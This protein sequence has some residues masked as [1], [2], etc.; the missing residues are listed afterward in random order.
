MATP[1]REKPKEEE[2]EEEEAVL[3]I[4]IA[5]SALFPTI[6][7]TV[8]LLCSGWSWGTLSLATNVSTLVSHLRL[9][10]QPILESS[11]LSSA[12]T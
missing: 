9:S 8:D 11:L 12:S 3:G 1:N 7:T 6:S 2:E 10:A 5:A 4:F